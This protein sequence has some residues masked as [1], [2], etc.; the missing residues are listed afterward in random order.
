MAP[1]LL[2]CAHFFRSGN[3]AT[4]LFGVGSGR[5][6]LLAAAASVVVAAALLAT[7]LPARRAASVDPA[8]ALRAE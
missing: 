1:A 2:S 7:V 8:S 5:P 3:L 6:A 4:L